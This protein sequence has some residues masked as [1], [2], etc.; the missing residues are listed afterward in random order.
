MGLIQQDHIRTFVR[1][2]TIK[3]LIVEDGITT[4]MFEDGESLKLV[5]NFFEC[6]G[7]PD[8]RRGL[9]VHGVMTTCD[10]LAHPF[11]ADGTV[12]QSLEIM[13]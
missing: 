10:I 2:K 8:G 6:R 12:K 7:V 5:L 3:D 13:K 1:G 9:A 4:F 11:K